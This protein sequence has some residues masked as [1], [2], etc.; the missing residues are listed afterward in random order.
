MSE[1]V[2]KPVGT[3]AMTPEQ[4][5][6]I[7]SLGGTAAQKLPNA[8]RFTPE[9]ASKY[10][11][12]GGLAISSRPGHMAELGRRGGRACASVPGQMSAIA[13]KRWHRET[14]APTES[15]KS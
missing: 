1:V 11:R 12:A 3:A 6:R 13:R 5:A 14:P 10:A 15:E 7:S 2:K 8:R 9:E 4:R